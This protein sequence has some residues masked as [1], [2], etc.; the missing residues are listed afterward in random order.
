MVIMKSIVY[1]NKEI[2]ILES[3]LSVKT[4]LHYVDVVYIY[5]YIYIYIYV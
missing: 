2:D 3:Y 5:I 1:I 4:S